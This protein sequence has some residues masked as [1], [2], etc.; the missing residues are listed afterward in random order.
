[1]PRRG[2]SRLGLAL[3]LSTFLASAAAPAPASQG[4]SPALAPPP[5]AP[6]PFVES[7]D[8]NPAAPTPWHPTTWDIQ[9]HSRARS[10]WT[11]P[12]AMDAQHGHDCAPAP[13]VHPIAEW[14][15][16]VFLC[17]DHLMTSLNDGLYGMIYLTPNQLLDWSGGTATLRFDMSTLRGS[18][19]DWIDLWLTPFEHNL[20]LPLDAWLPDANGVPWQGVHVRMDSAQGGSIF[21]GERIEQFQ[22]TRMSGNAG[23]PYESWLTPSATRRDTFELQISA[24]RL[25]FGMP[26]FNRWWIDTTFDPPLDYHQAVVQLG[27]H[28]YNPEKAECAAVCGPNTWHWDN[29]QLS[30]A[31]PFNLLRADR[32]VVDASTPADV[33]FAAPAPQNAYLR[34]AAL[35]NQIAVSFDGGSS[36]EAAHLQGQEKSD[37]S[38]FQSYWMP[39]PAG[40]SRLWFHG[41]GGSWGAHWMVRDA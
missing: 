8:G 14:P 16:T 30:A 17:R 6:A 11:A 18:P 1:V 13:A 29:V 39:V 7:F 27:H 35:G 24:T 25:R 5:A 36:W 33:T 23:Q 34:F 26:A 40:T 38:H 41:R 31:V 20:A 37:P 15:D 19:R 32:R 28:S 10:N 2:A 3:L 22:T 12:L 9:Y 4:T 21:R